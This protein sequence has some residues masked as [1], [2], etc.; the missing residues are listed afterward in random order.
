MMKN[1]VVFKAFQEDRKM[2]DWA[3]AVILILPSGRSSHLEAGY[4]VGRGKKL[5]ILGGFERGE[6]ETMYGF[7]DGL[8]RF[9]LDLPDLLNALKQGTGS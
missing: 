8:Y 9:P 7:A 6:F 1:L 2:I 5:F 4:A 3:D